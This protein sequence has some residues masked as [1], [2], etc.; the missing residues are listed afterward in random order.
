MINGGERVDVRMIN[1]YKACKKKT[2]TRNQIPEDLYLEI[3]F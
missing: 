2:P 1:N 3:T